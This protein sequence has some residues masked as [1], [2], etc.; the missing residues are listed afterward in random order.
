VRFETAPGRQ[1]QN[2]W[3][4]LG[5]V[6]GGRAHK[7]QFAVNTL[8][9]SRRFRFVAMDC[10]NAVYTYENLILGFELPPA[11]ARRDLF[12]VTIQRFVQTGPLGVAQVDEAP[13]RP[14]GLRPGPPSAQPGGGYRSLP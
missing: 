3:A 4:D 2:D 1:L 12:D 10:A 11:P 14:S 9:Y 8:S 6:L 7:V 13:P 5:T